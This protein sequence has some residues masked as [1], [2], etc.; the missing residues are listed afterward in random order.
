[1]YGHVQPCWLPLLVR[2]G[3]LEGE[4]FDGFRDGQ[5]AQFDVEVRD[6]E[7]VERL[8]ITRQFELAR[9]EAGIF[10]FLQMQV[11]QRPRNPDLARK[12]ANVIS[13][14]RAQ[15]GDNAQTV[16]ICERR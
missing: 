11:E 1:M 8:T 12:L 6:L 10:E 7:I 15:C 4:R 3:G 9:D 14:V 5:G 13:P 2:L 16:R